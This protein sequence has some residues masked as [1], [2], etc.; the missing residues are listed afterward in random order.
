MRLTENLSNLYLEPLISSIYQSILDNQTNDVPF[1]DPKGI[2]TPDF[3]DESPM[4]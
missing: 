2:R 1:G 3:R 4:S